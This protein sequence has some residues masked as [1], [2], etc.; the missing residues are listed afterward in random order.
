MDDV[1]ASAGITDGGGQFTFSNTG[2]FAYLSGRAGG[3]PVSWLEASGRITPLIA[4]PGT[5]L[6][7]RLSPDGKRLAYIALGSKGYDVWVYDLERATPMQLTFLGSVNSELAWARDSKHLVYNDGSALWWIRADGSGQR[8][9]LL[10][11]SKFPRPASFSPDGRLVFSPIGGILPD[12]WTLPVDLA[13]P[14]RP[15]PG[16]A[17]PF[18][19]DPKMVDV[20]PAFSPDG[21]FIA[22]T[23]M[24]SGNGE[25]YVRP[26]PGPGGT[27]RVSTTGGQFP[28]WSAATHELLF[29]GSDERI[30]AA[31]FSTQGNSFNAG[32]PRVW[33][34]TPVLRIGVLQNF[35][36]SHDGKRVVMFPRPA[37][38]NT[39]ASLH[40]TFLLNFFDEVRR[41]VPAVK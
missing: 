18:L 7:P 26:F 6:A 23:S 13:D 2:T 29:L 34:P 8:Q 36:V 27:W 25:I 1:A 40:A 5:Y 11:K 35:D 4:Q 9:M 14:E 21:K 41:R 20:D 38:Q 28:A 31:T 32:S 30:M 15:K 24:E 3:Y 19:A 37:A 10:D 12:I 39:G 16:K 17:E 33:S 22:Y